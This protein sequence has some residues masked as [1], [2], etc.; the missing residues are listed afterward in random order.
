[1]VEQEVSGVQSLPFADD[2]GLAPGHSVQYYALGLQS[3]ARVTIDRG[4]RNMVQF[5][6][7]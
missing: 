3:A 4:Q 7:E 5:E 1:M 6:A 2:V